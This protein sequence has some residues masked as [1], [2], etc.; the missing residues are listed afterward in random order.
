MPRSRFMNAQDK[1]KYSQVTLIDLG[2]EKN[3]Q[4][5]L[6]YRPIEAHVVMAKIESWIRVLGYPHRDIFAIELAL[7]EAV[8]T[9]MRH[10]HHTDRT[11][12]SQITYLLTPHE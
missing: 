1:S 7:Y 10:G 11:K 12:A 8:T 6:V 9:A 3:A 4:R 5:Y 2:T